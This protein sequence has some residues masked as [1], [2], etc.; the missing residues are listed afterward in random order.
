M[1][2]APIVVPFDFE[3]SGDSIVATSGFTVD[4]SEYELLTVIC[5]PDSTFSI[6]GTVMLNPLGYNEVS[7]QTTNGPGAHTVTSGH[8]FEGQYHPGAFSSVVATIGG[9][10]GDG[11]FGAFKAGPG[12]S[13]SFAGGGFGTHAI[14]GYEKPIENQVMDGRFWVPSGTVVAAS[15]TIKIYRQVYNQKT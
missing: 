1:S 4:A 10:A 9:V 8:I 15:G 12:Q 14:S 2:G 13:I 6:D 5:Q 11:T 7:E 3:P